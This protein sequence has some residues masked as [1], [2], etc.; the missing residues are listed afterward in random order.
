MKMEW[1]FT[2]KQMFRNEEMKKIYEYKSN[3]GFIISGMAHSKTETSFVNMEVIKDWK[4]MFY[5]MAEEAIHIIGNLRGSAGE[6]S[7]I[8]KMLNWAM[9]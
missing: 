9:Y 8:H 6:E 1:V 3:N 5:V 4:T 2:R 7:A